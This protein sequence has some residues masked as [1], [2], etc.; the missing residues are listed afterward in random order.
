MIGTQNI[1][2]EKFNVL[3]NRVL[4]TSD[5]N[6][7]KKYSDVNNSY[8][9]GTL[10]IQ[11][12]KCHFA[13]FDIDKKSCSLSSPTESSDNATLVK[14]N[15]GEYFFYNNASIDIPIFDE[16]KSIDTCLHAC[17]NDGA[18]SGISFNKKNSS[19]KKNYYD[20]SSL[21][22]DTHLLIHL[23]DPVV[24]RNTIASSLQYF[25]K[26]KMN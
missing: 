24:N 25:Y 18:C 17:D 16:F 1:N 14:L 10:C 21:K 22:S 15:S 12:Q 7:V 2:G 6:L 23:H 11:D 20:S 13:H 9:C 3:T 5:N 4:T 26:N 8:E 19:C